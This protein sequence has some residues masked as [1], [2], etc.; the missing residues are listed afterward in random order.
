MK[1]DAAAD[2]GRGEEP[3]AARRPVP[4]PPVKR[5]ADSRPPMVRTSGRER[6]IQ[7]I[8][9]DLALLAARQCPQ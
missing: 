2:G 4:A 5:A 3:P 8:I 6:E 9:F 1:A 7:Q